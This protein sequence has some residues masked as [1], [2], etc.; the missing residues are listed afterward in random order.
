MKLYMVSFQD[1]EWEGYNY[2]NFLR[3]LLIET[4]LDII[5]NARDYR[6]NWK[7]T[8]DTTTVIETHKNKKDKTLINTGNI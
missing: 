3:P 5:E 6:K 4:C 7:N 2:G 1:W 8:Y